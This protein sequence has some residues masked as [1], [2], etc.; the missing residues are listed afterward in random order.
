MEIV[1]KEVITKSELRTFVEFPNK[2]FRKCKNYIPSLISDDLSTLSKKNPAHEYC[3]SD[4]NLAGQIL[5]LI[6]AEN[7]SVGL[8]EL[9][10][11]LET[12]GNKEV[13]LMPTSFDSSLWCSTQKGEICYQINGIKRYLTF[14][15]YSR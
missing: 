11:F 13:Q 12:D 5:P 1:V 8:A 7:L 14:C 6:A 15:L 10:S 4:I 3:D 2:L 9:L